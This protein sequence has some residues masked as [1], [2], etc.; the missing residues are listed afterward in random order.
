MGFVCGRAEEGELHSRANGGCDRVSNFAARRVDDDG[1]SP[2]RVRP[3]RRRRRYL[4]HQRHRSQS[5]GWGF[6]PTLV[7]SFR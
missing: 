5:S 2:R 4:A 1:G 3:L 7:V 6:L